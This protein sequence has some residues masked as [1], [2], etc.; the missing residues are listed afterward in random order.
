LRHI[1]VKEEALANDL[2]GQLTAGGDFE[3]LAK[4]HS[5]DRSSKPK[6]G[7][8]N[9]ATKERYVP[10]FAEV[11]FG[12]TAK[13]EVSAPVKTRFGF[14]II[15][16]LERRDVQ[17]LDDVRSGIERVLVRDAVR[18]HR[19][20]R[21]EDLGLGKKGGKSSA[22]ASRL[23]AKSGKDSAPAAEAAA[24]SEK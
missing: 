12:L 13:G 21:R 8:L 11:A 2:K 5:L 3:A 7:E 6:G 16:L 18:D 10:A 23:G 19:T 14:H 15:E 9:W 4:E 17:P 1:L 22:A 24:T 20:K